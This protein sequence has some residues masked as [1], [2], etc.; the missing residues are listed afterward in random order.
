MAHIIFFKM[1]DLCN[2]QYSICTIKSLTFLQIIGGGGG[3]APR[4]P[5]IPTAL[6]TLK[7][8]KASGPNGLNNRNLRELSSQ[9]ASPFCSFFNQSLRLGIMPASYKEVNVCPVP[10]KGDLSV[11]SNYRPISLLNSESKVFEKTIFKHLYNHLQENNMLSSFSLV[12]F[13]ETQLYRGYLL[14]LR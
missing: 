10:K 11:T 9:L 2:E 5:P 12:L 13:L 3:T 7:V 6:Q 4:P 1:T 8:G 14:F